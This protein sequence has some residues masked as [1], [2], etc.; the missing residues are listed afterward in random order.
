MR[1]KRTAAMLLAALIVC[2]SSCGQQKVAVAGLAAMTTTT[3]K[4]TEPAVSETEITEA[5]ETTEQ[6]EA[7]EEETAE[8]EEHVPVMAEIIDPDETVTSAAE[9]TDIKEEIA[10]ESIEEI[11]EA[12]PA[13]ETVSEKT[14]IIVDKDD[15]KKEIF[16]QG[17]NMVYVGESFDYTCRISHKNAD[18]SSVLWSVKGDAGTIDGNGHFE[19]L[20]KGMVTL[21]VTDVSNNLIDTLVVHCVD[22]PKDVNFVVMVNGI[23][24]ANK[25]YPVPKNYDPGLSAETEA[26]FERLVSDA[27]KEGL[28][29]TFNSGYRS[30]N[31][32]MSVFKRWNEK[33]GSYEAD[34]VSARPGHSEHQL[35]LAIDVCNVTKEFASTPEAKWIE[36][37]C[38]KYGFILRYPSYA[39]ESITGY[40]YEAWHI[41]YLGDEIA[42]DVHESGLTLEEYLG[43]D[44]YYRIP[45]FEEESGMTFDKIT[46]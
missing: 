10:E 3:A 9:E 21:N 34:R 46:W 22:S 44:S 40:A 41:R 20:K 11:T 38:W 6:T 31:Y 17:P 16:L 27:S 5:E 26:A 18:R 33:F 23:P 36:A 39:S 19:A 13:E 15:T 1:L 8:T 25:T 24:I 4:T 12:V 37:N 14:C 45:T 43:I 28:L 2:A 30:Y 29:I 32:Q 35:G 7:A 42:A